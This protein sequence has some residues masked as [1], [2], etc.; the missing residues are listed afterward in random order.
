MEGLWSM[1]TK[2]HEFHLSKHIVVSLSMA[3]A[4]LFIVA[5]VILAMVKA[6]YPIVANESASIGTLSHDT[7]QSMADIESNINNSYAR[8]AAERADVCPKLLQKNID[9]DVIQRTG[10]VMVSDYC[11]YFLYPLNGE[12]IA[13]TATDN[14][15]EALLITPTLHNFADG[16]YIVN[17]YDKH[18][19]RLSYNGATYKPERLSYDVVINIKK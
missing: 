2:T 8:L 15:I 3:H 17:S 5:A 11:D 6:C 1:L 13:I 10:E 16:D 12:R 9:S 14:R 4:A 19:I 18:V 7:K